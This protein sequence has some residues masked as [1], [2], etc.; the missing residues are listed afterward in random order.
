MFR[1]DSHSKEAL[2][3][4]AVDRIVHNY[5]NSTTVYQYVIRIR[6]H[7]LRKLSIKTSNTKDKSE[8]LSQKLHKD[9]RAKGKYSKNTTYLTRLMLIVD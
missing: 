6:W 8:H 4:R 2:I 5:S 3:V 1:N 9:G 7:V